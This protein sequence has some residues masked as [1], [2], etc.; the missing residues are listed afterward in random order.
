MSVDIGNQLPDDLFHALWSET[1]D[2]QAGK[3]IVISTIDAE[4]WSHP[5][6]LSYR[7]VGARD[8]GTL[9]VVT[10]EGSSTTANMRANG[11]LTLAFV[12]ERM[13]YY[14]KGTAKEVPRHR[15]GAPA[16]YATMDVSIREILRDFVGSDEAGT[17]LTSGITFRGPSSAGQEP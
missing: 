16:H 5:A 12:D 2:E 3:A 10:H 17:L 9:R 7:E 1:L 13:T 6:L 4:G 11:K 14:V 8:R 15:I